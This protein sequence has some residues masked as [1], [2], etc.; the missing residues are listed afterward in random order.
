M[1][2]VG[3]GDA[4]VEI[5]AGLGSLTLPLIE[6]GADV[7]AIEIDRRLLPLLRELVDDRAR[8]VEG[9]VMTIDWDE[10]LGDRSDVVVVSN[11]PYNIATPLVITLL[12]RVPRI[13]RLVVMVQKEVAE[14]IASPPG[15]KTY[16]AV[17]IRVA[18]FATAK[19]LGTVSPEVFVPRPRVLSAVVEITRRPEPAI[20]PAVAT[21]AEIDALVRA[22]FGG[23]R[24]ML[25]RSLAGLVDDATFAAAGVD[26]TARPEELGIERWGTLA[27]CRR[28]SGHP[29][30]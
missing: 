2:R 3:A 29:P 13:A 15:N 30:S 17:S 10:V 16:G 28:T 26:P 21:Y 22:G 20:D 25:R 14:R 19:V 8:I 9:D 23:R 4:V 6:S 27:A 7:T 1:A 18:Y 12:E 11:L 24:K 5:G